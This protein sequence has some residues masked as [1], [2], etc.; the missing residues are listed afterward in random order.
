MGET[1]DATDADQQDVV[2]PR[3]VTAPSQEGWT[4]FL[5]DEL[6]E[7]AQALANG[8]PVQETALTV[9]WWTLYEY[10]ADLAWGVIKHPV[11]A[12]GAT[13]T[14]TTGTGQR[15][16]KDAYSQVLADC[17]IRVS[18]LPPERQL[19]VGDLRTEMLGTLVDVQGEVVHVEA[20]EPWVKEAAYE[21]R[22]CGAMTRAAQ[23]YGDLWKPP[24]CEGCETGKNQGI[25][26]LDQD[27]S[28]LVD[29]QYAVLAPLESSL[30]D[31]PTIRLILKRD[32]VG[33]I[34]QG[35]EIVATGVYQTSP[36]DLQKETQLNVY[37]EGVALDVD[38][39]VEADKVTQS[40]LDGMIADVI[41]DPAAYDADDDSFGI[42]VDDLAA[43]VHDT[44]GVR[45][46]EVR[47]RVEGGFIDENPGYSKGGARVF[48]D[49]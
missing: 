47:A 7:Q 11:A 25:F 40:E 3:N 34:E 24:Q 30:E 21:C 41:D 36:M 17:P 31:P 9:D 42:A 37:L 49:E 12:L 35:D 43:A 23:S 28:Q 44:H 19:R 14:L 16:L 2:R 8:Y 22:L 46:E 6:D 4:A 48:P 15:A 1:S 29:Y 10:S 27:R 45:E 20:V 13:H 26:S 33:R 18:D 5:S 38:E 32:L 39:Q